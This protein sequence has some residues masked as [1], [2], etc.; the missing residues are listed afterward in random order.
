[1]GRTYLVTGS[2]GFIGSNFVQMLLREED[3][4]R[5][6]SVDA[7]T[8]A[9][10][11]D[12]LGAAMDDA[13]HEFVQADIR[14]RAAMNALVGRV[15]PDVIVNFAAESH[16][17]RS[18][19]N[20]VT[21]AETNTAGTVS[22]LDAALDAWEGPDGFGDHRFIQ[23]STDEVYGSLALGEDRAFVETDPLAP[24]SPYSASKASADLYALAYFTT[25]GLPVCVT[26]CSNNYGP[27]Q[28]PEKLIPVVIKHA[29]AHEP[30]PVYGDGLHV[31]D[32]IHVDDH[33]AAVLTVT[34]SGKPGEVYNVGA[35]NEVPNI[36]IVR[37]IIEA[38][39]ELT[40]DAGITESLIEHVVGRKGHDR[41]YSIDASKIRHELGWAPRVEFAQGLADTVAWYV[42]R[43]RDAE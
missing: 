37:R 38:C 6:V 25:Y 21:F 26:R 17:D 27:R 34:H 18:I 2:A 16:V 22:L 24:R 12:N 43:G 23:I 30:I 40:G 4:A 10:N 35:S 19:T 36:E 3:D 5:V 13:R 41:R 33:C 31:R 42:E 7:L 11:V 8:Y 39:A 28:Y 14:D 32:W 15:M 9:G 29:L 20:P 1:M